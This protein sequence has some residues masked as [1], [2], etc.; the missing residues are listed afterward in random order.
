MEE[1]KCQQYAMDVEL[2]GESKDKHLF[3][4]QPSL[5]PSCDLNCVH[6]TVSCSLLK[7]TIEV[8]PFAGGTGSRCF[9]ATCNDT[10]CFYA[11][12]AA[13]GSHRYVYKQYQDTK[14]T[15][16]PKAETLSTLSTPKEDSSLASP[17]PLSSQSPLHEEEAPTPPS[18][19]RSYRLREV[20]AYAMLAMLPSGVTPT[21][22]AISEKGLILE[23][24]EPVT[25]ADSL[26]PSAWINLSRIHNSGLLHR[27]IKPSNIVLNGS[28]SRFIDFDR[29]RFRSS[30]PTQKWPNFTL[31]NQAEHTAICCT[32][33][34]C[35]PYYLQKVV[36]QKLFDK[37]DFEDRLDVWSLAMTWLELLLGFCPL[38]VNPVDDNKEQL[39]VLP[40]ASEPPKLA[41]PSPTKPDGADELKQW[42]P[43]NLPEH[44]KAPYAVLVRLFQVF[45]L[46]PMGSNFIPKEV[47]GL[48]QDEKAKLIRETVQRNPVLMHCLQLDISRRPTAE[49]VV[50]LL[51]Q[52]IEPPIAPWPVPPHVNVRSHSRRQILN[53]LSGLCHRH[54]VDLEILLLS[55]SLYNAQFALAQKKS[56]QGEVIQETDEKKIASE[57]LASFLLVGCYFGNHITSRVLTGFFNSRSEEL[58]I[59]VLTAEEVESVSHQ[60]LRTTNYRVYF[61]HGL[62]FSLEQSLPSERLRML[63]FANV[64]GKLKP[65]EVVIASK[66]KTP[67]DQE[68]DV[69]EESVTKDSLCKSPWDDQL[70]QLSQAIVSLAQDIDAPETAEF[71]G[72]TEEG[73]FRRFEKT[74]KEQVW[75]VKQSEDI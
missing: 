27:D 1:K 31:S 24:G 74:H 36:Q 62:E 7:L 15:S 66:V 45:G 68:D 10:S 33:A 41:S 46:P 60:I 54:Q 70:Y 50:L 73:Q 53:E 20:N 61:P 13:P 49:Q 40:V 38:E 56:F 30:A 55:T 5:G 3:T 42:V 63:L 26:I 34:Y 44:V 17:A 72:T 37:C 25:H 6:G 21:L 16:Q 2:S 22:F 12:C 29:A 18:K 32:Y 28:E 35:C 8:E 14:A 47:T 59:P 51:G 58:G 19:T 65:Y 48:A 67:T 52:K 57:L 23:E 71:R 4:L 11:T 43:H 75:F 39:P 64:I 9:R 69:K